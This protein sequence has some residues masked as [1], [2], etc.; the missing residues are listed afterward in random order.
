MRKR[1]LRK[2]RCSLDV[3]SGCNYL[4]GLAEQPTLRWVAQLNPAWFH[5]CTTLNRLIWRLAYLTVPGRDVVV[6]VVVFVVLF[7]QGQCGYLTCRPPV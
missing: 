1:T 6:V 7:L 5:C 3:A 2:R 4:V